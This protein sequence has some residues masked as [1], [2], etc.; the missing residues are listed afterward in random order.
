MNKKLSVENPL[1]TNPVIAA[2]G[3]GEQ[4]TSILF[5]LA[6]LTRYCP[7]SLIE[8]IPASETNAIEDPFLSFLII[9]IRSKIE[10]IG[11]NS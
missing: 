8:G 7:G 10:A 4:M 11:T 2:H 9:D 3:P 6:C 5:S 1:L